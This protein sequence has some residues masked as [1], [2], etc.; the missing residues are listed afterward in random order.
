MIVSPKRKSRQEILEKFRAQ[1]VDEV[2]IIGGG[3]G[4]GLSAK[5]E[6]LGGI[7]LI[8]TYN[9]GRFR[10]GGRPSISGLL[11]FASANDMVKELAAQVMPVAG[12][13]PV[14][15]GVFA[16]DNY[17]FMDRHLEELKDLGFAGVQNFPSFADFSGAQREELEE[18]GYGVDNEIEM[19]RLAH[20]MDML[21]A[22]YVFN[23]EQCEAMT[24]AG[25]D[26]IVV[27]CGCTKGG[28]SGIK[29]DIS[30]GLEQAAE[31]A[32]RI[33][34]CALK[35]NP[36]VFVICHGGPIAESEDVKYIL[37][38]TEHIQ[39]FFGASSMER[40]PAERAIT[41]QVRD[42]KALRLK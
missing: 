31:Y 42:F 40:L 4:I 18:V 32:E 35:I 6:V 8:I 30:F 14:L 7:D 21:T 19:I 24:K 33:A 26:I 29:S 37:E 11:P 34:L 28:L 15:A 16:Q 13:T 5:C 22:P 17:R 39:G 12:D 27:H 25:A 36:E 2:P 23:E 41:Q 3:A 1:V 10:M 20:D 38:H 9:S